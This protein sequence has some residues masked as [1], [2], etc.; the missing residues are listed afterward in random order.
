MTK[1]QPV[2]RSAIVRGLERDIAQSVCPWC[3]RDWSCGETMCS[4]PR[5][6]RPRGGGS[7]RP[8]GLP[9]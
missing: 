9:E 5:E 7:V 2:I 1:V 6:P 3:G 8:P 4:Q